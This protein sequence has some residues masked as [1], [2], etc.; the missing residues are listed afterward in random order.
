MNRDEPSEAFLPVERVGDF[1]GKPVDEVWIVERP[2]A[3]EWVRLGDERVYGLFIDA[4]TT[5]DATRN[6][7]LEAD[8][9]C[10]GDLGGHLGAA[11]SRRERVVHRGVTRRDDREEESR[12][13]DRGVMFMWFAQRYSHGEPKQTWEMV[14]IKG[15]F[16]VTVS[17]TSVCA[18]D[19]VV[20]RHLRRFW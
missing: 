12:G 15:L 18:C 13:N 11:V 9:R 14:A 3:L 8:I 7:L 2:A 20:I 6:R 1:S 17:R 4:E 5:G 10:D 16:G 19:P